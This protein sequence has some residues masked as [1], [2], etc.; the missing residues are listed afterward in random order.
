MTT[1]DII[2]RHLFNPFRD[3]E[4][5]KEGIGEKVSMFVYLIGTFLFSIIFA[6]IY[7]WKLT[8]VI[9]SCSPIIIVSTAYVAKIQTSLTE[10]ELRAYSVAGSVAEEVLNAIKTVFAFSGQQKEVDRYSRRL[11]LAEKN[12]IKKGLYTGAGG[13]VMWLIIYF[14][15]ALAFYYGMGLILDDRD[16]EFKEYTP[17]ALLIVLFGVLS[18]AQNLGLTLPHLEAFNVARASATSIFAVIARK[19]EIDSLSDSG[20]KPVTLRGEMI[21]SNIHFHYPARQD[22]TVLNG[23][24]LTIQAGKTTALVGMS[25]CGKST[26]MQLLQRM[27]DPTLVRHLLIN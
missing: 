25:G 23:L 21:F 14:I 16:K 4:K 26:L 7:G 13:G 17:A 12:G 27:Y 8:L 10:K 19:P 18:G 22:V 20:I 15:Y 6:F 9:L 1:S 24:N 11:V 2:R 3:L 5:L